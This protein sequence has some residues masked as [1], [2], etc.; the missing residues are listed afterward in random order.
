M[1]QIKDKSEIPDGYKP[2]ECG[3]RRYWLPPTHCVFCEH[4]DSILWDYTHGMYMFSCEVYG[5]PIKNLNYDD[6]CEKFIEEKET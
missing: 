4:C 2:Y 1:P 5:E 3:N 6:N